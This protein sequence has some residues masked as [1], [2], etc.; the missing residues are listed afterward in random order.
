MSQTKSSTFIVVPVF[1]ESPV[2]KNTISSI[3]EAGFPNIIVVDDGSSDDS[4]NIIKQTGVLC[5][6]HKINRGKG[7][8]VKTGIEAAKLRGANIIVTMDGDGQH[9]AND[10]K[11]LIQPIKKN[12]CDVVLGTRPINT[13]VMPFHK[14]I[15][16]KT[17][18]TVTWLLNGLWVT[19]SQSGFK[20]FSRQATNTINTRSSQY[21]YESDVIR[22]IKKHKLR[23]S[24][25]P[26]K[27]NY[28]EYSINKPHKQDLT[29]GLKT[30][31]KLIWNKVS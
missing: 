24:E 7:A 27:V 14:V 16:N 25:V 5:F 18:N 9:N 15:A 1:N 11:N 3:K 4:L 21:E 6:H 8:A 19:D 26:I 17:G 22:E 10:I 23:F 29:N 31:F 28:T 30:I 12:Q 20:A 2:I 13:K